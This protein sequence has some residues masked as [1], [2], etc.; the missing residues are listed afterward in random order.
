[1]SLYYAYIYFTIASVGIPLIS[2]K[3]PYLEMRQQA[4]VWAA[5]HALSMIFESRNY[6][7]TPT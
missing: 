6:S 7:I 5:V 2:E 1:M 3:A 4:P